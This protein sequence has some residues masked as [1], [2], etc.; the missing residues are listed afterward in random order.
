M[1]NP[2]L[3]SCSIIQMLLHIWIWIVQSLKSS[4]IMPYSPLYY[5]FSSG[6]CSW[7]INSVLLSHIIREMIEADVIRSSHSCDQAAGDL[8]NRI[9]WQWQGPYSLS[10]SP[11]RFGI[12]FIFFSIHIHSSSPHSKRQRGLEMRSRNLNTIAWPIQHAQD[13]WIIFCP[14][15]KAKF[16]LTWQLITLDMRRCCV[17]LTS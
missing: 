16:G 11:L 13:S 1:S 5:L 10:A 15:L 2:P 8:Q 14:T 17:F 6:F 9:C 3:E 7:D 4:F 12:N